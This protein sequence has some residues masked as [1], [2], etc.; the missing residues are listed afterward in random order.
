MENIL[1]IEGYELLSQKVYRVLK[2]EIV[3]GFLE[4]GT[5]LFEDKIATQMGV[6]RTP[7]REAIQKLAAEGLIKIAPNQ[8]LI[9]KEISFEDIKEVLQIRGVLEGLAVRMAAQKINR[10][11]V[12]ELEEIVNQMDLYVTKKDL[13]SYCKADDEFHNLI[14]NVCGNKR[15]IN[16]RD[17]LGN[18]IYRYRMRSLSIPGRLKHSLEEHRKIMES[19]K[20]RNSEDGDR[21]SQIHMENTVI[22]ILKNVAKGENENKTRQS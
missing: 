3:K 6:S 4:P 2:T 11:E 8:T 20:K 10:R 19:L 9:V 12:D 16:I 15:I 13:T 21:L 5:K 18:F 14:L 1:K 7:V 22:N 17:N